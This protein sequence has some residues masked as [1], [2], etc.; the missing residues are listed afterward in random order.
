MKRK[1]F[2]LIIILIALNGCRSYQENS[3][4]DK[5]S[6]V[7][8]VEGESEESTDLLKSSSP[9]DSQYIDARNI[10][11]VTMQ[12]GKR[13]N[14]KVLF[15]GNDDDKIA[16]IIRL[17]NSAS[18]MREATN[19]EFGPINSMIR[20]IGI[21]IKMKD[22][23]MVYVWP[24]YDV[25]SDDGDSMTATVRRDSF[26]LQYSNAGTDSYL[27]FDSKEVVSYLSGEWENVMPVVEE[28]NVYSDAFSKGE[29]NHVI[30]KGDIITVKGDGCTEKQ[31]I[32]YI[33]KNGNDNEK[34]AL[35]RV[36]PIL[37][38]W[39]WEGVI[40]RTVR[41]IEDKEVTLEDG[42]YSIEVEMGQTRMSSGNIEIK[43]D[44]YREFAGKGL[45]AGNFKGS[46]FVKDN[47]L[48]LYNENAGSIDVLYDKPIFKKLIGMSPDRNKVAFLCGTTIENII[49]IYNIRKGDFLY[50]PLENSYCS[51]FLEAWWH[52]DNVLVASGHVN[53]SAN[54]YVCYDTESGREL[55]YTC[56]EYK[57]ASDDGRYI[58]FR[59]TPHFVD[60]PPLENI[61]SSNG[62][63]DLYSVKSSDI[64]IEDVKLS[65]DGKQLLFVETYGKSGDIV[66]NLA[67]I[68]HDGTS[69]SNIKKAKISNKS[70][71]LFGTFL[72]EDFNKFTLYTGDRQGAG[73]REVD[74]DLARLGDADFVF[75]D[76]SIDLGSGV[77]REI[78]TVVKENTR[79]LI[80]T[81]ETGE[82]NTSNG[83]KILDL[84]ICTDNGGS[85]KIVYEKASVDEDKIR[86]EE[87]V[88]F[89]GKDNFIRLQKLIRK[90]QE[91]YNK[92]N[93]QESELIDMQWF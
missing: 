87:A 10:E 83:Q 51:Q 76:S 41:T 48:Y 22:G 26:V 44:Y 34:Y 69:I 6:A 58:L 13:I 35:A 36:E 86:K 56:G 7:Q 71:K 42:I 25:T 50:I 18:N 32:I 49:G 28:F 74:L 53:P 80:R 75:K 67:D 40:S 55:S 73:L 39:Q 66:V 43:K 1:I 2:I 72:S 60:N 47:S 27:T 24:T 68:N 78:Y 9:A 63:A 8:F 85:Y 81:V 3:S 4:V 19:K 84:Q 70:K 52:N 29:E 31:V 46:V 21:S 64:K 33:F 89:E 30:R 57:D 90:A 5:P 92:T 15:T 11:W 14:T 12:G 38:K 20:P 91:F 45:K 59:L 88:Y 65:A 79:Y 77:T 23:N 37:G 82:E 62:I 16:G 54:G 61:S 93:T 17:I